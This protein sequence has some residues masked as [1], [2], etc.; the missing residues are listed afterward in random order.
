[1]SGSGGRSAAVFE[2]DVGVRDAKRG[3]E[4]PAPLHR[5]GADHRVGAA[6][7][8]VNP[9]PGE[10]GRRIDRRPAR[11]RLHEVNVER[12]VLEQEGRRHAGSGRLRG[13]R[14]HPVAGRMQDRAAIE[15][16]GDQP[17]AHDV[18]GMGDV[19]LIGH[20]GARRNAGNRHLRRIDRIGAQSPR[21]PGGSAQQHE[22]Q[23]VGEPDHGKDSCRQAPRHFPRSIPACKPPARLDP[24][25]VSRQSAADAP[26][27][28]SGC[29]R[30]R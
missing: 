9:A 6:G 30:P 15:A 17:C 26:L 16:A 12:D 18:G 5:L 2:H 22:Q 4:V 23:S 21:R 27:L 14:L 11:K 28:T 10:I 1:M 20:E 3:V 7:E 8:D 19:Q 13:Q 24:V 25:R 29:C